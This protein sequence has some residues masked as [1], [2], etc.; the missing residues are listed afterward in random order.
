MVVG[1]DKWEKKGVVMMK[2]FQY[3]RQV[4]YCFDLKQRT[5]LEIYF[6]YHG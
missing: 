5:W 6:Y 2:I 1:K 4:G 3:W